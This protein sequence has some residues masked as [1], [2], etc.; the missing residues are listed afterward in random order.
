MVKELKHYIS[1]EWKNLSSSKLINVINPANQD[2]IARVPCATKEET[3][4]SIDIA[5]QAFESGV[6]SE[7]SER[8]RSTVLFQIANKLEKHIEELA[9]LEVENNGKTFREAYSDALESVNAFRY[10]GGL[11]Q[12]SQEQMHEE[13]DYM[14][15]MIIK[16]PI[17]VAGLI[18]PWNFP[19]LMSC[20]KIAPALAA[21]NSI[22]L[23]PAEITP[24]TAVRVFELIDQTDLPKGVANL[25]MGEG[26]I[27]GQ[28]ISESM[29]V[30]MVSFT[31]ST[32]VGK[33]IMQSATSNMKRISLELGG[34]SPNIIF[35]DANIEVAIDYAL[36]G[37]FMG[38]GQVCSSG[39]RIIVE[40]DI[41][42]AFVEK[43]IE[44]AKQ[45]RTEPGNG[46]KSEMGAIVSEAHMNSI[47]KYIE[48][49]KAEGATLALGGKRLTSNGLDKGF[50][51]EPTVFTNVTNEMQI[52][53]EEIFGPV[54]VIQKFTDERE[55]V[56][57]ANDSDY[58]LAGAV[59][60]KDYSKAYRVIKK[61]K[62]GI[63]WINN[64]HL[65][66]VQSPWGGYKQSGIGRSLG[67]DG[68]H[69]YQEVKQIN[70]MLDSKPIGWFE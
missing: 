21:G 58:G 2:M 51:I 25:V 13:P 59:F 65:T 56:N 20:W 55:A 19:L 67:V 66:D 3:E 45:I 8:E 22:L 64:Y 35:A 41:Y 49:G 62:A 70:I 54:V 36:F 9:E 69:E 4:Y 61:V 7:N 68:L 38:A 53:K 39:S 57:I 10:Y 29:D 52:A 31:G 1:G 16:E 34:K 24:M 14:Q 11:L 37:I 12:T 33:K 15:T 6:W 26:S 43:F 60:S 27:V 50:F 30:D 63:T 44:R 23:K 42:D 17:G 32:A 5:K 46:Q 47:L 18:V 48:I 40:E 28:T